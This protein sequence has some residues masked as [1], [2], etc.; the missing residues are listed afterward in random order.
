MTRHEFF[1]SLIRIATT[2][3]KDQKEVNTHAQAL[4]KF[5]EENLLIVKMPRNS[6]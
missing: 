5:F 3:Y 6:Q 4:Q 1:E 2:R